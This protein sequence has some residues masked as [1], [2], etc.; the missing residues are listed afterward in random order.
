[1][2]VSVLTVSY[3]HWLLIKLYF[4]STISLIW[5]DFVLNYVIL[6]D[7]ILNRNYIVKLIIK[8]S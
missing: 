5:R 3:Q 8:T 7:K 2:T 4:F 6:L 1:M